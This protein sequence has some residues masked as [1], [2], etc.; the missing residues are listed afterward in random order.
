MFLIASLTLLLLTPCRSIYI[1]GHSATRITFSNVTVAKGDMLKIVGTPNGIE[2][3]PLDY[4]SL[5]PLGIVD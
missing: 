4:V 2:P 3:A 1:D 5:L